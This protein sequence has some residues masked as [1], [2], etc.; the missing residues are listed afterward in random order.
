MSGRWKN[1]QFLA[2]KSLYLNIRCEVGLG[3]RLLLI[4][5]RKPYTGLRL[6]PN[7]MTLDDLERQNRGFMDLWRFRAVRH[8]STA[9]YAETN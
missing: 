4:T 8:I 3:P 9:N 7:S 6:P 5:N 1:L 2:N